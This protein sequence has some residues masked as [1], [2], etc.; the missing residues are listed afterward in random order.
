M[1]KNNKF[2]KKIFMYFSDDG[3]RGP[4]VFPSA[5]E[6]LSP[7]EEE[8]F[9]HHPRNSPTDYLRPNSHLDPAYRESD[10]CKQLY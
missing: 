5:M 8:G 2:S 1:N 6:E 4:P 9:C 7:P 10:P 3:L